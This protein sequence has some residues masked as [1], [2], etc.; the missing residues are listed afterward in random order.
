MRGE[1][2]RH[3]LVSES[4]GAGVFLR[5]KE[6]EHFVFPR[7][8]ITCRGKTKLWMEIFLLLFWARRRVWGRGLVGFVKDGSRVIGY[9]GDG[10]IYFEREFLCYFFPLFLYYVL[11]FFFL[12]FFPVFF[13]CCCCVFCALAAIVSA[14][15]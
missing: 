6:R 9:V 8:F 12:L 1:R 13:C 15:V 4:G 7:K 3:F 5:E 11:C 10:R 14:A 2:D